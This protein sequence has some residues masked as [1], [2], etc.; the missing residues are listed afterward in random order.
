MSDT[1]VPAGWYADPAGTPQQRWWDGFRWTNH[2][3]P[4]PFVMS[5]TPPSVANRRF[6]WGLGDAETDR[7][8]GRNS[9]ALHAL[10]FGIVGLVFNP[11]LL[12]S[13]AALVWGVIGLRRSTVGRVQAICGMTLGLVSVLL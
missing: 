4:A 8:E 12:V 7:A 3:Q 1:T 13:V 5:L 9:P 6:R 2:L 11:L 10:I